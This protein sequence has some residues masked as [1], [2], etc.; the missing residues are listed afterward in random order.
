MCNNNN[1]FQSNL[2]HCLITCWPGSLISIIKINADDDDYDDDDD[3]ED[4]DDDDSG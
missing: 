3:D 4:D 1:S 2:I